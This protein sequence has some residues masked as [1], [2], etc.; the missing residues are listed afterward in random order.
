MMESQK[1]QSFFGPEH[2]KEQD[3][4]TKNKNYFDSNASKNF[5]SS[6]DNIKLFKKKDEFDFIQNKNILYS[7]N[8]F[9][10]EIL[11]NKFPMERKTIKKFEE[12]ENKAKGKNNNFS[13]KY[14]FKIIL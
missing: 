6:I 2:E 1:E 8:P 11:S 13:L 5:N 12:N 4:M 14:F 9:K 3:Y 7:N 10:L